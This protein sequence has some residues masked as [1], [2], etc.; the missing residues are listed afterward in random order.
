MKVLKTVKRSV[1]EFETLPLTVGSK[2]DT[3]CDVYEV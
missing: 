1:K 3:P 2:N